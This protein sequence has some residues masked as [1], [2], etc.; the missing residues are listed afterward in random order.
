MRRRFLAAFLAM[1]IVI[2]G[3]RNGGGL[4]GDD[5]VTG[6]PTPTPTPTG[7]PDPD[8]PTYYEDVLPIVIAKCQSCH[9]TGGIAPA[10]DT[11]AGAQPRSAI[12]KDFTAHRPL[13]TD[14][15]ATGP[16]TGNPRMPPWPPEV[17]CGETYKNPRL[18]TDVEID[19]F[20]RWHDAGALEG[21]PGNA[22]TPTPTP[23][24]TPSPTVELTG[25]T[26]NYTGSPV[27]LYQCFRLNPGIA[28][29]SDFVRAEV[30][31]ANK[32]VV[33][34]V[35][36]YKETNPQG[37]D[38]ES[39]SCGGIPNSG[40]AGQPAEFLVGWVPGA[41]PL[42][43]PP[44]V[45]MRLATTDR[46]LMQVHYHDVGSVQTDPG[47]KVRFW[48]DAGI[49]AAG[50][51][52]VMWAGNGTFSIPANTTGYSANGT[53]TVNLAGGVTILGVSP[54]MHKRGTKFLARWERTG[55]FDR[56]MVSIDK[57]D[58]EWQGGYMFETPLVMSQN[59]KI[60]TTCTWNNETNSPIGFGEG[61]DEE[62]CFLFM[63]TLGANSA[64]SQFCLF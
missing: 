32:L 16:F 36:L 3:C 59:D 11:Y 4:T 46:I 29:A 13:P 7:T 18:T 17:A 35:I 33:H 47:T 24:P 63:Y 6:T 21:N 34:H 37:P 45:G 39:F 2:A 9:T 60:R 44:N 20:R 1:P 43:F 5:D 26:F 53:C 30:I 27:D 10:I 41:A 62:M 38:G 8:P 28:A 57:W 51:A 55:T 42:E 52:R 49:P 64:P 19:T 48:F 12:M 31:P 15:P 56:C 23:M 54:H 14:T 22:P 40:N 58:F 25:P 61:T 50:R